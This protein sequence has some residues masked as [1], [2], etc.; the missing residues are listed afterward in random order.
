MSSSEPIRSLPARPHWLALANLLGAGG[1]GYL[2]MGQRRKALWM[3]P[4]VTLG[5]IATC[6]V[7]YGLAFLACYDVYR[8]AQR[9]D[10][11][12][13]IGHDQT[14]DPWLCWLLRGS[15]VG[16]LSIRRHQVLAAKG[17]SWEP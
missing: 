11:G 2:W 3:V 7:A 6:G 14:E 13:A 17:A 4:L 12:E 15:R 16:E 9:V 5:G 1:V 8:L 10:L